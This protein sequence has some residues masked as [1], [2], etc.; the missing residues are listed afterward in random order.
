MNGRPRKVIA[1]S[2]IGTSL[3]WVSRCCAGP[4]RFR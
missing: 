1:V 3:E 2:L 4:L